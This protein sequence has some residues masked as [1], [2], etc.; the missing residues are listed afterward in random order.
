MELVKNEPATLNQAVA[1]CNK[2]QHL[3]GNVVIS[4]TG[5]FEVIDCI[6]IAPYDKLNKM[7]FFKLYKDIKDA[8][9]AIDFYDDRHFD[10]VL[11]LRELVPL[12]DFYYKIMDLSEYMETSGSNISVNTFQ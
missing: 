12:G 6:A 2:Y 5:D 7:L 3:K 4:N 10:V 9:K 1:L 11:I 8:E